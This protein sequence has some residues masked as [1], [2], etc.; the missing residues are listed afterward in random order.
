MVDCRSSNRSVT[1]TK[2]EDGWFGVEFSEAPEGLVV[3]SVG[4]GSS[5]EQAGVLVGQRLLDICA[6]GMD[7]DVSAIKLRALANI[8][9]RMRV[10]TLTLE[11]APL[12]AAAVTTSHEDTP[13]H[14]LRSLLG[15][16][17]LA[18]IHAAALRLKS[19]QAAHNYD[20]GLKGPHESLFLHEDGYFQRECP[21]VCQKLLATMRALHRPNALAEGA[22]VAAN[23]LGVRCMEYHTCA[24]QCAPTKPCYAFAANGLL[25]FKL[26]DALAV[27]R[28]PMIQLLP[29]RLPRPRR[30]PTL[31]VSQ[32]RLLARP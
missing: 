10:V 31:Q 27:I 6:N 15:T 9:G 16:S 11:A 22:R 14:T 20:N 5:A 13:V 28:L 4:A 30:L 8:L 21:D 7:Y 2:D 19:K 23:D 18:N 24:H 29:M 26:C 3:L 1:I 32:G 12:A 25:L 17:D